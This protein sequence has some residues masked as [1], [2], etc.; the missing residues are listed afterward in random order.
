[1]HRRISWRID[2]NRRKGR[3]LTGRRGPVMTIH[4]IGKRTGTGGEKAARGTE[5]GSGKVTRGTRTGIRK[6][7]RGTRTGSRKAER[8]TG[9]GGG[10]AERGTGIGDGNAPA[11][12]NLPGSRVETAAGRAAG[13]RIGGGAGNRTGVRFSW[14]SFLLGSSCCSRLG[15]SWSGSTAPRKN[16]WI[17][18]ATTGS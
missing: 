13:G 15:A 5:A 7:M 16:A 6:P 4:R 1:M 10:K 2:G 17:W 3:I 18:R 8:V 11:A 14:P 12:G 9:T